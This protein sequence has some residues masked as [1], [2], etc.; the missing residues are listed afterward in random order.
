MTL[1][2][3]THKAPWKDLPIAE[4]RHMEG[5]IRTLPKAQELDQ[6]LNVKDKLKKKRME[7]GNILVHQ[8]KTKYTN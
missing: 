6:S 8:E 2:M 5:T 7:Y 3:K 4:A 1:E